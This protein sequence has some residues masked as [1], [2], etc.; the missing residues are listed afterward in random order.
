MQKEKN[1]LPTLDDVYKALEKQGKTELCKK[2]R[3]TMMMSNQFEI[4]ALMYLKAIPSNI[5]FYDSKNNIRENM[6]K[7]KQCPISKNSLISMN[8]VEAVSIGLDLISDKIALNNQTTVD[9]VLSQV[10]GGDTDA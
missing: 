2:T 5:T 7:I 3:Q 10:I 6:E 8:P 9:D 4:A 1:M